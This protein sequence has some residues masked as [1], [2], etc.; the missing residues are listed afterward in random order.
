MW[1]QEIASLGGLPSVHVTL[2]RALDDPCCSIDCVKEILQ[3]D[4]DLVVRLLKLAN[5]CFYGFPRRVD[6]INEAIAIIG[7]QQLRE[8]VTATL[9]VEFFKNI[10][11]TIVDMNKFWRHS[12]ACGITA[13]VLAIQRRDS[14]PERFFAAGLLHDVGRLVLFLKRP[15]EVAELLRDH[16]ED[17]ICLFEIERER[18]G[19]DHA[20]IGGLLLDAWN[21]PLHLVESVGYHHRPHEAVTHGVEAA[22]VHISDIIVLALELGHSGE[23]LPPPLAYGA[24]ARLGLTPSVI[25]PVQLELDRQF[26]DVT[27]ALLLSA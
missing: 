20:E 24:W 21:C 4:P 9:V 17:E 7:I 13:R 3:Y 10:D 1:A 14:H 5:S 22:V 26:N 8:L 2:Q 16:Q 25:G 23:R 11:P 6:T 27:A 15:Q 19:Q 12:I 18:F